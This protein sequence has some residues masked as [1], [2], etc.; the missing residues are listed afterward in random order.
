MKNRALNFTRVNSDSNGNPRYVIHFL[1]L[2]SDYNRAIQLSHKIGGRKYHTKGFGG[3][4]VFQSYSLDELESDIL[5][6]S[7]NNILSV[8]EKKTGTAYADLLSICEE[9]LRIDD[10]MI[11]NGDKESQM[12]SETRGKL[13]KAINKAKKESNK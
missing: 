12:D 4:I 10:L 13:K 7:E 11:W 3:G 5:K 6:I 8:E 1:A 2:A 9:I